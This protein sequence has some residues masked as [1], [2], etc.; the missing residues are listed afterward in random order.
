MLPATQVVR[1]AASHSAPVSAVTVVLPFVPVI[2]RTFCSGGSARAKSSMSPTSSTPRATA[3]AISGWSF[4]TPGLIA[5][6]S[7]PSNVASLNGPVASGTPGSSVASAAASGGAPRV[8]ATRT[9]A[10]SRTR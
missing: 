10:P 9:R 3:A 7:A 4:A 5:I 1:P 6:R 8:S 2:A